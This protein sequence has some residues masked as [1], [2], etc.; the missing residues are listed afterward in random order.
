MGLGAIAG[1]L[2]GG[3]STPPPAYTT[4]SVKVLLSGSEIPDDLYAKLVGVDIESN[5]NLPDSMTLE[6]FDPDQTV[7]SNGGFDLGVDLEV[8]LGFGD[9]PSTIAEGEVTAMHV[10]YD[11]GAFHTVIR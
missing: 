9:D 1:A 10:R 2:G 8:K 3:S 11:D 4:M 7:I 6:F 5:L